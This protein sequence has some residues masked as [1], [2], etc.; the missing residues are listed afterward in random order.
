MGILKKLRLRGRRKNGNVKPPE[1]YTGVSVGCT[2]GKV[3]LAPNG[4]APSPGE[5]PYRELNSTSMESASSSEGMHGLR[6]QSSPLSRVSEE[7]SAQSP[8]SPLSLGTG[9]ERV[10]LDLAPASPPVRYNQDLTNRTP[11]IRGQKVAEKT[12]IFENSPLRNDSTPRKL[13]TPSSHAVST[14]LD[15]RLIHESDSASSGSVERMAPRIRRGDVGRKKKWLEQAFTPTGGG[16]MKHSDD[17]EEGLSPR[18]INTDGSLAVTPPPATPDSEVGDELSSGTGSFTTQATP[19]SIFRFHTSPDSA[20]TERQIPPS[21]VR[22]GP[23]DEKRAYRIWHAKGLLAFQPE[24]PRLKSKSM[25]LDRP[26]NKTTAPDPKGSY[27]HSD[28]T[29][30]ATGP[31]EA[32]LSANTVSVDSTDRQD[33]TKR[34]LKGKPIL[35]ETIYRDDDEDEEY[36]SDSGNQQ[37]A[38]FLVQNPFDAYIAQQTEGMVLQEQTHVADATAI[39]LS[40]SLSR[41]WSI[42]RSNAAPI[43]TLFGGFIHVASKTSAKIPVKRVRSS[44]RVLFSPV[45]P[46]ALAVMSR[47]A[48]LDRSRAALQCNNVSLTLFGGKALDSCCIND[49]E[50]AGSVEQSIAAVSTSSTFTPEKIAEE[51]T[52]EPPVPLVL[53]E[54]KKGSSELAEFK[55]LTSHCQDVALIDQPSADK[56]VGSLPTSCA[57]QR[58][59]EEPNSAEEYFVSDQ[60]ESENVSLTDKEE[61]AIVIMQQESA[62]PI[63]ESPRTAS[64]RSFEFSKQRTKEVITKDRILLSSFGGKDSRSDGGISVET[65]HHAGVGGIPSDVKRN[66]VVPNSRVDAYRNYVEAFKIYKKDRSSV[67]NLER[68][69]EA[70]ALT[71]STNNV[72][73]QST[74]LPTSKQMMVS[75]F[76]GATMDVPS[77]LDGVPRRVRVYHGH[78]QAI[79]RRTMKKK[80]N[81]REI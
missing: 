2:P 61:D 58:G 30:L 71:K 8:D 44:Q 51:Q 64:R 18:S 56:A 28:S 27:H 55:G 69:K 20:L 73:A 4:P 42:A 75:L 25:A 24:K 53:P 79:K 37:N 6:A 60:H 11:I 10:S 50:D 76:T 77:R 21:L 22:C 38:R 45:S 57:D 1:T 19:T 81:P 16:N 52:I 74:H 9:T 35:L 17:D 12:A 72:S 5:T 13:V 70:L 67:E 54:D 78:V 34:T 65:P 48:S 47:K 15:L 26:P 32:S 29:S 23:M 62:P 63:P 40:F 14:S 46:R 41:T 33:G 49:F 7:L 43:L 80:H 68:T 3:T 39:L 66:A 59:I 36:V 31:D